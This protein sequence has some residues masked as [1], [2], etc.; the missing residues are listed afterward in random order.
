[1][2]FLSETVLKLTLLSSEELDCPVLIDASVEVPLLCYG[3]NFELIVSFFE[4]S[5]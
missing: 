4:L 1:M 3:D 5:L 2:G